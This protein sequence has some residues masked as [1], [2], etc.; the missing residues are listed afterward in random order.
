MAKK[1]AKP[2][3]PKAPKPEE[4]EKDFEK[5]VEA[6]LKVTPKTKSKSGG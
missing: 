3:K 2:K 4:D 6:L 1:K 5:I